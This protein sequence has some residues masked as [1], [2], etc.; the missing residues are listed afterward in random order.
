[1]ILTSVKVNE[2]QK[3]KEKHFGRKYGDQFNACE[4]GFNAK[5][6]KISTLLTPSRKKQQKI[7]QK[8]QAFSLMT[9]R[10]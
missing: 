4:Y 7:E 1:M 2:C 5:K 3:R 9:Q 10:V 8:N 6:I